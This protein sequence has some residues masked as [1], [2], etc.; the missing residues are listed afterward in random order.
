LG[1]AEDV[2]SR[3]TLVREAIPSPVSYRGM[4]VSRW[5]EFEDGQVNLGAVDAGPQD[6]LRLLLLGFALDYGND[7]FLVP[8]ELP[9]G[10]IYRVASLVVTDSFG[11][12]TQVARYADTLGRGERWGAFG[13]SVSG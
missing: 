9:S 12:R 7:W 8:V 4:P 3:E 10:A 13:L 2:A 1:A 11:V 5:W 6:L